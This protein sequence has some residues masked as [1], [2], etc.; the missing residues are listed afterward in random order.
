[1]LIW[2][3]VV[4]NL[5]NGCQIVLDQGCGLA[6]HPSMTTAFGYM[7]VSGKGQIQGDGFARQLDA[8]ERYAEANGVQ[9][10]QVFRDEGVSGTKDFQHRPAFMEMLAALHANGTKLILIEK[11][12]RL[13]RDLVVQESILAELRA[14]GFQLV[15]V[16]EPD[17]LNGDPSRIMFRQFMGAI[18][19]YDKTSIVMKLRG[20]RQRKKAAEGRCEGQKPYGMREGEVAVIERMCALRADGMSYQ[21]IATRLTSDGV[22]TRAGNGWRSN[23]VNTILRRVRSIPQQETRSG[24]IYRNSVAEQGL[25]HEGYVGTTEPLCLEACS[26]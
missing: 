26:R 5:Q 10:L 16:E 15:S 4:T 7:R 1:M 19:Q 12:D 3:E 6:H 9:I 21:R 22:P 8:I 2:L 18:A 25:A 11:L 13:A 17:L 23:T 24:I 14:S 20:A